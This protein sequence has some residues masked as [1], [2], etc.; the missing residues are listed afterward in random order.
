MGKLNVNINVPILAESKDGKKPASG[1]GELKPQKTMNLAEFKV[2]PKETA[3]VDD[4]KP[5]SSL[6]GSKPTTAPAEASSSKNL[7]GTPEKKAGQP[8]DKA[9]AAT[10]NNLFG[11]KPG[12]SIFGAKPTAGAEAKP[13]DGPKSLFGAGA[14][15]PNAQEG[16]S[17]IPKAFASSVGN[18]QPLNSSFLNTAAQAN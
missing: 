13:A 7:F 10:G 16:G 14:P 8:E 15:K 12:A 2:S 11:A 1:E 17:G 4:K 5:A 18:V 9:P 6:F 3:K